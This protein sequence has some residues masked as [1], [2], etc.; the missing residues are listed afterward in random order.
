MISP[1]IVYRR[2][3][4]KN[5]PAE[6]QQLLQHWAA[7]YG[8]ESGRDF[9]KCRLA[10]SAPGQKPHFCQKTP[11]F[12]LSHSGDL[13]LCAFSLSPLGLDMEK[14]RPIPRA[15]ALARRFFHPQEQQWLADKGETDFF[16]IWTAKEAAV[17]WSGQGIN[18]NF[19]R[20]SVIPALEQRQTV[21]LAGHNL[22]LRW[23]SPQ[24]GYLACLATTIKAPLLWKN[25]YGGANDPPAIEEK[26]FR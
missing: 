6:R 21:A 4:S 11:C 19:H 22:Y 18:Q 9:T 5:F 8:R 26:I 1:I 20:F 24:E 14:L 3:L 10:D 23:L 13:L 7:D 2:P 15:Q 16:L 17:K 25:H 12:S